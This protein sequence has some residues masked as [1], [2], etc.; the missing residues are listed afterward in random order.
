MEVV[1]PIALALPLPL[2]LFPHCHHLKG[3]KHASVWH[4]SACI[5]ALVN[6][7]AADT[8]RYTQGDNVGLT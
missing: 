2:L 6:A 8:A 1:I 7:N 4:V 5:I 3:D